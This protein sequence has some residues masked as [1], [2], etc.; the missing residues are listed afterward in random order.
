MGDIAIWND[1]LIGIIIISIICFFSLWCV[2]FWRYF[3]SAGQNVTQIYSIQTEILHN[4]AWQCLSMSWPWPRWPSPF[5]FLPLMFLF[6]L[7]AAMLVSWIAKWW[8]WF[9]TCAAIFYFPS[10]FRPFRKFTDGR[11]GGLILLRAFLRTLLT[12]E[13]VIRPLRLSGNITTEKGPL[14]KK[15]SMLA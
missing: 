9:L 8:P 3:L 2:S 12:V 7:W 13:Q 10:C 5:D 6:M 15:Q 11:C 14:E 1:L 4:N